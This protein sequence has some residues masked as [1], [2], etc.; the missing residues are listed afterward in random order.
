RQRRDQRDDASGVRDDEDP[1][2]RD[3]EAVAARHRRP[4]DPGEDQPRSDRHHLG[5][6]RR[7]GA[8][9]H[10][11]RR[12]RAADGATDRR[13]EVRGIQGVPMTVPAF[14]RR[15]LAPLAAVTLVASLLAGC[16][17]AGPQFTILSGSENDVLEPL[18]QEFCKSRNTACAM[19]YQGSL[20][21]A[22]A[23]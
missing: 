14:S 15:L 6:A 19:R 21:I 23:L 10:P 20:D 7:A 16:G 17:A 4:R 13:V 18:V 5:R 9:P 3:R 12:D 1:G 8:G 11:A 22:L 2:D